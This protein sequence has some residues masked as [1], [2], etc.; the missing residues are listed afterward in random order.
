MSIERAD[1]RPNAGPGRP[2][3]RSAL[4][5]A[6]LGL[7]LGLLAAYAA[8]GPAAL[9]AALLPSDGSAN[10]RTAAPDFTLTT[11]ARER[12][13]LG[14]LA[15]KAVVLNFWAS[16]CTPCRAEL[17]Y[18]ERTYRAFRERGVIFVGLAIQDDPES[19]RAFLRELGITYPN[20]PDE[21]NDIAVRYQV[22]GL[23]T[24]VFITRDGRLAHRRTGTIS[25][26]QLVA[27][28][29]EIAR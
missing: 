23:P 15:G 11:F 12:L 25:E 22:T 7:V 6:G 17:P 24:T 19:S 8:S 21:G 28:V 16:W 4:W 13:T 20:G 1:A 2:W 10:S 29:E 5:L 18:F 14:D 9:P 27:L 3:L 26:Q